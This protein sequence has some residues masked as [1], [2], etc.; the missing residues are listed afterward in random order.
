MKNVVGVILRSELQPFA[1]LIHVKS[2]LT[3]VFIGCVEAA[4]K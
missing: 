4:F 3:T 1:T 2:D